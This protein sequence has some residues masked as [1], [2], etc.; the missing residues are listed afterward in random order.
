MVILISGASH[1]GKTYLA[2]KMLEKYKIP[3][4]SIDH[5]KMGLIRSKYTNL[6][7]YDDEKLTE[8]LWPVVREIVKTNIENNQ[9]II[10]EGCYIPFWWRDD[11]SIYYLSHIKY[12]CLCFS[13]SYI[14][15]NLD[16]IIKYSNVIESRLDNSYITKEYLIEQNK[17]YLEGCQK[18]NLE[19]HIFYD[20]FEKEI[21]KLL[22]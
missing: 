4:L 2:Q 14:K 21:S 8:Y 12:I 6:T 16:K 19:Y 9:N 5:I 10:I 13:E 18:H 11:F 7:P 1:C 3:Y 20:D 15:N 17:Y 22:T